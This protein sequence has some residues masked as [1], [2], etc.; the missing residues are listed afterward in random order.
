MRRKVGSEL[1][2]KKARLPNGSLADQCFPSDEESRP[3]TS[4]LQKGRAITTRD[5]PRNLGRILSSP[6]ER[7]A[8]L[9]AV[10]EDEVDVVGRLDGAGQLGLA[11]DNRVHV[12]DRD[13]KRRN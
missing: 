7:L 11:A 5:P 13:C 12:A 10:P 6:V 8:G 3:R 1:T 4:K 9:A 2:L